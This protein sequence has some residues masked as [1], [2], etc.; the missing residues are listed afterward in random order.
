MTES[1][2]GETAV[3]RYALGTVT[4]EDGLFIHTGRTF[5]TKEGA[6]K[7]LT[8]AQGLEWTGDDSIDDYC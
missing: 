8:L 3:K 7:Q 2:E 5:F 6:E 1:S 4:F